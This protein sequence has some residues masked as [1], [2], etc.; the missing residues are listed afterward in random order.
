MEKPFTKR[1]GFADAILEEEGIYIA[2]VYK[3][4]LKKVEIADVSLVFYHGK[5]VYNFPY[6]QIPRVYKFHAISPVSTQLSAAARILSVIRRCFPYFLPVF[7]KPKLPVCEK[8]I[9][10]AWIIQIRKIRIRT[11]RKKIMQIKIMRK[12]IMRK[13]II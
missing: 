11:I 9:L 1:L 7:C 10:G 13:K 6:M 2:G 8:K 12:K 4:E 5:T 3:E